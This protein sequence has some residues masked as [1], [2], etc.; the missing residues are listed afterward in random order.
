MYNG[1]GGGRPGANISGEKSRPGHFPVILAGLILL[2]ALSAA[3]VWLPVHAWLLAV[4]EW[5]R[6]LGVWGPAAM[7]GLYVLAC[8]LVLPGWILTVGSGFLFGLGWGLATVVCGANLGAMAAFLAGRTVGRRWIAGK[9]ARNPRFSALD[10]AVGREGFKLVLLLRLS[11]LFPFNFLNYALGLTK[12]TFGT[13]A[14]ASFLGMLPA[15]VL[16]VYLGSAARSLAEAA[17]SRARGGAVES[18]LFWVGLAATA[19]VAVLVARLARR[20]L[21]AAVGPRT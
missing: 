20:S 17:S 13:Y 9:V 21:Q 4:L 3:L 15:M 8:V 6:S 5:I 12:I 7:V 2:A 18:I 11:P 1:P 14:L 10:Q 16:Y 19:A